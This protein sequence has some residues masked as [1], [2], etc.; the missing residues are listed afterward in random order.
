MASS[1]PWRMEECRGAASALWS[2]APNSAKFSVLRAL[3]SSST[4]LWTSS[5]SKGRLIDELLA[6]GP[7]SPLAPTGSPGSG[8]GL[9]PSSA[10][11]EEPSPLGRWCL[12]EFAFRGRT[13]CPSLAALPAP[14]LEEFLESLLFAR[15][16]LE[17][18]GL[19]P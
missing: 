14:I 11:S 10:S 17:A 5:P 13:G 1:E 2:A 4:N 7:R 19:C 18:Q 9:L 3:W 6:V 16:K 8:S 15:P 12:R